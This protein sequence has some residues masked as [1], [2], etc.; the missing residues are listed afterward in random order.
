[1]SQAIANRCPIQTGMNGHTSWSERQSHFPSIKILQ[2]NIERMLFPYDRC[3]SDQ[4]KDIWSNWIRTVH[5]LANKTTAWKALILYLDKKVGYIFL[6]TNYMN[7]SHESL[8]ESKLKSR[9]NINHTAAGCRKQSLLWLRLSSA[10][11]VHSSIGSLNIFLFPSCCL[12]RKHTLC[13]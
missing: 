9:W 8:L 10:H 7:V 5:F 12:I 4:E 6:L 1:M 3:S 2:F 11:C 13:F